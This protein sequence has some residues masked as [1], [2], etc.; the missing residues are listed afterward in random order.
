[1]GPGALSATKLLEVRA[2]LVALSEDAEQGAAGELAVEW[3]QGSPPPSAQLA[4]DQAGVGAAEAEGVGEGEPDR[5][6]AAVW[7]T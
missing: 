2:V 5:H 3:H 7:G 1:M 6:L 4:D